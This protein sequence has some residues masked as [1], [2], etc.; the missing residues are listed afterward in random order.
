M[1][2]KPDGPRARLEPA[3]LTHLGRQACIAASETML[4]FCEERRA[5]PVYLKPTRPAP[6]VPS[7]RTRSGGS[8]PSLQIIPIVFS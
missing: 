5:I 8:F 7:S 3:L 1:E 6:R 2:G 4:I